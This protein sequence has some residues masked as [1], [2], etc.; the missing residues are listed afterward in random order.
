VICLVAISFDL[1]VRDM[2]RH[3]YLCRSHISLLGTE[4]LIDGNHVK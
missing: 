4:L 1:D 2:Y 3:V